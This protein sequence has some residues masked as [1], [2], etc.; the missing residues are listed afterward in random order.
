[1]PLLPADFIHARGCKPICAKL[2]TLPKQL[3][4]NETALRFIRSYMDQSERLAQA[5]YKTL[6]QEE[7]PEESRIQ[8]KQRYYAICE[9]SLWAMF[10][11]LIR[12]EFDYD[13]NRI[14]TAEQQCSAAADC[15]DWTLKQLTLR[16][17]AM[18]QVMNQRQKILGKEIATIKKGMST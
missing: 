16:G 12:P 15:V 14:M 18:L 6:A 11:A 7:I 5:L 13:A 2:L 9:Q 17:K 3:L 8:A 10:D 1:M 4:G